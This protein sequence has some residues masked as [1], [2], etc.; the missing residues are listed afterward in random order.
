MTFKVEKGV[1]IP[2][3]FELKRLYPFDQMSPGDSFAVPVPQGKTAKMIRQHINGNSNSW[4][5]RHAPGARFATRIEDDGK[6]VRIWLLSKPQPLAPLA[7]VPTP[8]PVAGRVH[9]LEDDESDPPKRRPGRPAK[10]FA[11]AI[12]SFTDGGAARVVKGK[13]RY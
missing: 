12:P 5:R 3:R 11:H 6:T 10:T 7:A 8:P 1:P 9:K 13:G 4:S 2:P